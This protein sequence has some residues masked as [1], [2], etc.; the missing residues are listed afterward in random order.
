MKAQ[1][2][3]IDPNSSWTPPALSL[4]CQIDTTI[5]PPSAAT[6][7]PGSERSWTLESLETDAISAM[8]FS[9]RIRSEKPNR[10][11]TVASQNLKELNQI[12]LQGLRTLSEEP[13]VSGSSLG[14]C[15]FLQKAL[16]TENQVYKLIWINHS[17]MDLQHPLST[18]S[19][20]SFVNAIMNCNISKSSDI[21]QE[22]N[23]PVATPVLFKTAAIMEL[24]YS[25]KNSIL[26]FNK[27]QSNDEQDS[28]QL[29]PFE[30][31]GRLDGK[32][33]FPPCLFHITQA[34]IPTQPDCCSYYN[35]QTG[36]QNSS[37]ASSPVL[38]ESRRD[39]KAAK[40]SRKQNKSPLKQE[41]SLKLVPSIP[42]EL[43][44]ATL[45]TKPV[46]QSLITTLPVPSSLN[47]FHAGANEENLLQIK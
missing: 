27:I 20:N 21:Y 43:S 12:I 42:R 8:P 11:F 23:L 32:R 25:N 2:Y 40:K 19:W 4:H 41:N 46:Y 18:G 30:E 33:D 10:T 5:D 36:R 35:N 1:P 7:L 17:E 34:F 45:T 6:D 39:F 37:L 16:R 26:E 47:F 38:N 9:T 22:E 44:T 13:L 3:S 15:P 24:L 28:R 29:P 31:E 14:S